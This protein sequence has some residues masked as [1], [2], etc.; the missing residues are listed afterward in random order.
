MVPLCPRRPRGTGAGA[1]RRARPV[2]ESWR[3]RGV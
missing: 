2:R 1:P 3:D